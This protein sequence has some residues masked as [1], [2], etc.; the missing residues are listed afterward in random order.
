[1]NI[2]YKINNSLGG[3]GVRFGLTAIVEEFFSR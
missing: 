2:E 3:I 1:M